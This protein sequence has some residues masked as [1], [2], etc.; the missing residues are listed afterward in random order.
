LEHFGCFSK[1]FWVTLILTEGVG[2][3]FTQN[4]NMRKSFGTVGQRM[5]IFRCLEIP[6]L[7]L[8]KQGDQIV[9]IFAD[10]EISLL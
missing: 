2:R 9:R 5:R 7:H 10:W 8:R 4:K 1:T 3:I 6:G